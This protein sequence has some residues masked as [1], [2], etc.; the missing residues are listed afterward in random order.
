[1]PIDR[2]DVHNLLSPIVEKLE[3]LSRLAPVLDTEREF[4]H[5]LS[6]ILSI[7]QDYVQLLRRE[8]DAL[9][10]CGEGRP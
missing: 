8:L 9:V 4:A 7:I 3:L 10:N 5:A 1:M 6:T 2:I